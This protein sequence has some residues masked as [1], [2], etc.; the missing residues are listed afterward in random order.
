MAEPTEVERLREQ[1]AAQQQRIE[2]LE[3]QFLEESYLQ[4]ELR[5]K[6]AEAA[7]SRID[8]LVKE[9]A[10]TKDGSIITRLRSDL[11][12]T[13]ESEGKKHDLVGTRNSEIAT[14]KQQIVEL[15]K[16]KTDLEAKQKARDERTGER[17]REIRDLNQAV[18]RKNEEL[19]GKES[20][21]VNL[22]QRVADFE[23]L[24]QDL[25]PQKMA[26]A[27][28]LCK[29]KADKD[30]ALALTE[31]VVEGLR[32][33]EQSLAQATEELAASTTRVVGLEASLAAERTYLAQVETA[34]Q[35]A[36]AKAGRLAQELNASN[37][38]RGSLNTELT[39]VR[40]EL[41]AAKNNFE[42]LEAKF[43]AKQSE[44]TTQAKTLSEKEAAHRALESDK[45]TLEQA[46]A[47]KQQE[48]AR[49]EQALREKADK[50]TE[51]EQEIV[52]RPQ[53][54]RDTANNLLQQ[55]EGLTSKLHSSLGAKP[56]PLP[57]SPMVDSGSVKLAF[58][59]KIVQVY[60]D[61]L[62]ACLM[63]ANEA[64]SILGD[65]LAPLAGERDEAQQRFDSASRQND[66]R[67]N[68][69]E[70]ELNV[71]KQRFEHL[72]ALKL[73]LQ[74]LRSSMRENQRS[75]ERYTQLRE[76]LEGLP[77]EERVVKEALAAPIPE[78]QVQQILMNLVGTEE[79]TTL[80]SAG[81]GQS[82]V[83]LVQQTNQTQDD[84][85]KIANEQGLSLQGAII[86]MLL[87]ISPEPDRVGVK[88][89]SIP[90]LLSGADKSGIAQLVG[91][92][93]N[94]DDFGNGF[95]GSSD[96]RGTPEQI[97]AFQVY[98][99]YHPIQHSV[100]RRKSA[101]PWSDQIA[102]LLSSEM[103]KTFAALLEEQPKKKRVG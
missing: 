12:K 98:G 35:Q 21:L 26:Q 82:G 33:T 6:Q 69:F 23:T 61:R 2:E 94:P 99:H 8:E 30:K 4:D 17:T 49:A 71:L 88:M 73:Q 102:D 13:M 67:R 103:V 42:E 14:L 100:S 16:A 45:L 15:Q 24:F 60:Q 63:S 48:L 76:R 87:E 11:A 83:R 84:L 41:M 92:S 28:E 79:V 32:A 70:R 29:A 55:L 34:M 9:L 3:T 90:Q 5:N 91:F 81:L 10:G 75:L 46:V 59:A 20:E 37:G 50:I 31:Q 68:T 57:S 85:Q 47:A 44:L 7:Q 36:Q 54:L 51:L 86:L 18:Q 58:E 72:T 93:T 25:E 96:F 65:Q 1:V 38:R 56:V 52:D 78:T 95:N 66:E 74:E 62:E 97:A 43:A 89:K 80:P 64:L 19:A 101:L 53:Q 27:E 40:Q 22:R 39:L 77:S